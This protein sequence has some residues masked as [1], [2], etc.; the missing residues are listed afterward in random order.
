[1]AFFCLNI[2]RELSKKFVDRVATSLV[3]SRRGAR[4]AVSIDRADLENIGVGS[5]HRVAR[6]AGRE[7]AQLQYWG[8]WAPRTKSGTA[9]QP[10]TGLRKKHPCHEGGRVTIDPKNLSATATLTFSDEFNSLSLWN[11]TSGT[12]STKYPFAPDKGGS[13][14][15]NGEQ[16]WYINSMYAPTTSVRP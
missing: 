11:G 13:L 7:R 4:H 8:R 14:P 2:L 10:Q 16:E 12:W 3:C 9:A 5:G 6:R 15:S 1:T